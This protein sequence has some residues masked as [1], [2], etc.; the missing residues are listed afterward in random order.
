MHTSFHSGQEG[1]LRARGCC[2]TSAPHL[3][4][5]GFEG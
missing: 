1:T 4:P 5:M 3:S 2:E